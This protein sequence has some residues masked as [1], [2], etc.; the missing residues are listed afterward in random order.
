MLARLADP[1]PARRLGLPLLRLL[2]A[3]LLWGERVMSETEC[4]HRVGCH[5]YRHGTDCPMYD[6]ERSLIAGRPL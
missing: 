5:N 4:M 2:P 1:S 3:L 6:W